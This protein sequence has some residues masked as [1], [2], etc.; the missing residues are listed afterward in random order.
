MQPMA[1]EQIDHQHREHAERHHRAQ[2]AAALDHREGEVGAQDALRR[3]RAPAAR[4]RRAASP[5]APRSRAGSGRSP[6]SRR[7]EAAAAR[8]AGSPPEAATDGPPPLP[9]RARP[10]RDPPRAARARAGRGPRSASPTPGWR[11]PAASSGRVSASGPLHGSAALRHRSRRRQSSQSASTMIRAGVVSAGS[12]SIRSTGSGIARRRLE[13]QQI[14]VRE[15]GQQDSDDRS[16]TLLRETRTDS[17]GGHRGRE[18]RLPESAH[19]HAAGRRVWSR[20]R[21]AP[22]RSGRRRGDEEDER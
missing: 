21:P 16:D 14:A 3:P 17:K 5:P 2:P 15:R 4:T 12:K 22:H 13:E 20:R 18:Y 6:R 10:G 9:S 7:P 11:L 8:T 19:G 1:P